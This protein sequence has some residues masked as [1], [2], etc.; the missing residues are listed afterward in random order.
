M[1]FSHDMSFSGMPLIC[2]AIGF[3]IWL[4]LLCR[5]SGAAVRVRAG[6]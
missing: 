2:V 1:F 4:G 3:H 5:S 6:L